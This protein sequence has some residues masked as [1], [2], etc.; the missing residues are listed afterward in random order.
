MDIVGGM[1]RLDRLMEAWT[2]GD[3]GTEEHTDL[4]EVYDRAGAGAVAEFLLVEMQKVYRA[5]GVRINDR[6]FEVVLNRMLADGSVKGVS[7]A[8]TTTDD[9]I[10]AGSSRDGIDALAKIAANNRPVTLDAI[11]NCTAF[12]KRIP[13]VLG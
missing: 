4:C 10:T 2:R 11:R 8:A 12:G 7:Q 3:T 9:F 5:Q 1:P 6:H 13:T